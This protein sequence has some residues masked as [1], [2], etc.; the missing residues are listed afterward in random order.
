LEGVSQNRHR[1]ELTLL[2]D[3]ASQGEHVGSPPR[4]IE[5]RWPERV[6]EDVAEDRG[7]PLVTEFRNI[8]ASRDVPRS[9]CH[10]LGDSQGRDEDVRVGDHPGGVDREEME[11]EAG[12]LWWWE[13]GIEAGKP[14]P[15][16]SFVS[17]P[18]R[19]KNKRRAL[20]LVREQRPCV[21]AAGTTDQP[22]LSPTGLRPFA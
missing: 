19:L 20:G 12:T 14:S 17:E 16:P 1:G 4:W 3:P 13:R 22:Q 18:L 7:L 10:R 9:L 8:G 11:A 5:S 21:S 15:V 6:A 2:V